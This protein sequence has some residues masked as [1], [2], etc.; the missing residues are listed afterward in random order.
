MQFICNSVKKKN[1]ALTVFNCN[2]SLL[3]DVY[4]VLTFEGHKTKLLPW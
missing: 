2:V 1:F 4:P 3:S